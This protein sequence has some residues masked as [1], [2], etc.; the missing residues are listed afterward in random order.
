VQRVDFGRDCLIATADD[1][2][3]LRIGLGG[4]SRQLIEIARKTDDAPG[5][6]PACNECQDARPRLV[7]QRRQCRLVRPQLRC[8]AVARLLE[9]DARLAFDDGLADGAPIFLVFEPQTWLKVQPQKV[10][11]IF[12]VQDV[13]SGDFDLLDARACDYHV[14][15]EAFF[16][17][18][19]N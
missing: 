6:Q 2:V 10:T 8:R 3:E 15:R 5:C 7:C 16:A 18:L 4:H 13:S 14:M 1:G 19:I 11:G 9:H 17:A 12:N